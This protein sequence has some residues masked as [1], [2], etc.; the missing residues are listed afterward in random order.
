[1]NKAG[2]LIVFNEKDRRPRGLEVRRMLWADRL[3]WRVVKANRQADVKRG[4]D[5]NLTFHRD[6][7]AKQFRQSFGER[8]P[9]PCALN[10]D[11]EFAFYL[12]ELL[13]DSLL[14]LYRDAYAGIGNMERD[15]AVAFQLGGYANIA[16]A[17]EL[18]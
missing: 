1:M 12:H 8:K 16:A 4:A 14:I 3:L 17:S 9:E 10:H 7:S 18:Q 5:A 6:C 15:Q 11:L 2:F 13:E